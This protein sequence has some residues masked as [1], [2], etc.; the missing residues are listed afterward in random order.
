MLP[1]LQLMQGGPAGCAPGQGAGGGMQ[2]LI[3]MGLMFAVFY[4]M[5]I[6]PQAK[7]AKEH[8][9]MLSALTKGTEVITQGGIFGKITGLTDTT[10][11]LEVSEKVRIKVLRSQILGPSSQMGSA[12][13]AAAATSAKADK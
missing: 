5:L 7:K 11:T 8:R 1:L 6:R 4:F 12:E 3:L 10:V 9:E 2:S 13:G